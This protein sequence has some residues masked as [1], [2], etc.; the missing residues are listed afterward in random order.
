[1]LSVGAYTDRLLYA[2]AAS[3]HFRPCWPQSSGRAAER[4]PGNGIHNVCCRSLCVV[5]DTIGIHSLLPALPARPAEPRGMHSGSHG[6]VETHL[7]V[8]AARFFRW[9]ASLHA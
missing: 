8:L 5:A 6:A 1:M 9:P 7:T 3:E 4:V 2:Y